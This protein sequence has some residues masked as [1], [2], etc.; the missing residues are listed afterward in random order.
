MQ[1]PELARARF[2][3]V[4]VYCAAT[5]IV[6]VYEEAMQDVDPEYALVLRERVGFWRPLNVCVGVFTSSPFRSCN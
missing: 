5:E 4:L 2:V 1:T 6:E 3:D